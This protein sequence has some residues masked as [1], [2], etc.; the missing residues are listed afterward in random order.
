MAR[1]SYVRH[2]EAV[3]AYTKTP[4]DLDCRL[5]QRA[6]DGLLV[7]ASRQYSYYAVDGV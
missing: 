3:Y 1:T 2:D 5:L 4:G 7:A 6:G